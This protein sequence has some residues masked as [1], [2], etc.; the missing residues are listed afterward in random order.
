M[1]DKSRKQQCARYGF[2]RSLTKTCNRLHNDFSG[3]GAAKQTWPPRSA[4]SSFREVR[5][6]HQP[7]IYV[8]S[9]AWP[10]RRGGVQPT[11]SRLEDRKPLAK[12]R[13]KLRAPFGY[14]LQ[15]KALIEDPGQARVI[16]AIFA[17]YLSTQSVQ[18]LKQLLDAQASKLP[19][20]SDDVVGALCFSKVALHRILRNP[21]YAGGTGIDP[22]PWE[23]CPALVD[24]TTWARVQERLSLNRR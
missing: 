19:Q 10:L 17:L 7:G 1:E 20:R 4:H 11:L 24:K 5:S 18:R 9:S 6:M 22:C 3:R 14:R 13:A 16:R 8:S 12:P 15:G 21:V 23:D 2:C